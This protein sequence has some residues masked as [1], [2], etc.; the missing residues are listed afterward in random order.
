VFAQNQSTE[1]LG[2]E[3]LTAFFARDDL[4]SKET[5]MRLACGIGFEPV[6]VGRL[7]AARYL[8]P[9]AMLIIDKAFN[10]KMGTK[11]ALNLSEHD[12]Y[13]APKRRRTKK[14]GP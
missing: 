2:K 3:A 5:V 13:I 12:K 7:K 14:R 9:M 8:E 1:K 4:R 10:L 6:D 11:T